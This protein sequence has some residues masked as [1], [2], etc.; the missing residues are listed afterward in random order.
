[1]RSYFCSFLVILTSML[2]FCGERKEEASSRIEVSSTIRQINTLYLDFHQSKI[3]EKQF[4]IDRMQNNYYEYIKYFREIRQ[5]LASYSLTPKF[6]TIRSMIDSVT[7]SS[8]NL[9]S[10]RESLMIRLFKI[11]NNISRYEEYLSNA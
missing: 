3:N 4:S 8:I 11:I 7:S 2:Q 6:E 9:I 10:E 1:M 5:K